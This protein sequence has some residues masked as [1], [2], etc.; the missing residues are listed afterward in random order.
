MARGASG[1]HPR[2][3]TSPRCRA[4][5]G[6]GPRFST[7]AARRPARSAVTPLSGRPG[8]GAHPANEPATPV[9]GRQRQGGEPAAG[10]APGPC[11]RCLVRRRWLHEVVHYLPAAPRPPVP[12]VPHQVGAGHLVGP[13]AGVAEQEPAAGQGERQAAGRQRDGI[14]SAPRGGGMVQKKG[15]RGATPRRKPR[16]AGLLRNWSPGS[17]G[18]PSAKS[19]DNVPSL[20]ERA[21]GRSRWRHPNSSSDR[22][23]DSGGR[24][25]IWGQGR[26]VGQSCPRPR[27]R[28]HFDCQPSPPP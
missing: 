18:V 15:R 22:D 19:P 1:L 16:H 5:R 9:G 6:P 14:H 25:P 2:T 13:A 17:A 21:A 12:G 7:R 4:N 8:G 11:R 10:R 20:Q 26:Y 24:L 28:V 3:T 27:F 23:V